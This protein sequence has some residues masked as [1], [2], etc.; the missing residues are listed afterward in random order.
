MTAKA[1]RWL[2]AA[3]VLVGA[4]HLAKADG[5]I[6][7]VDPELRVRGSWAVKY[8]RVDIAVRD[9]IAQVTVDQAFVNT[10]RGEIEVEYLF[11]I[12]PGAAI[13]AMT[14]MADGQELPGRLMGA[15]EARRIYEEIVRRKKD[16]ALLEY[17]GYGLYRTSVFPLPPGQ[18]RR[19]IVNYTVPCTKDGDLVRIHYPLNT[20]KFSAR[21]IEDVRVTVD[22]HNGQP[23]G[24]VYSPTHDLA[25]ERHSPTHVTATYQ[26]ANAIPATDFEVVYQ[27]GSG[28]IGATVV[29]YRPDAGEDGYVM[30]LVS[31]AARQAAAIE[32]K[33]IV[34]VIDQSGSMGGQK[35]AQVREALVWVLQNLNSEDR[36]NVVPFSSSVHA[37]FTDPLVAADAEHTAR[38]AELV[39]QLQ[40]G[41]G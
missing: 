10:G 36:F 38:A 40:A 1:L 39:R 19:V 7:P 27:D 28:D 37:M 22:I 15:D 12:P 5:M 2:A 33:D 25:T 13:T 31:P 20:E 8:H 14:L 29:S 3:G 35:I 21:A 6:V 26:V 23:I 24:P 30:A 17:V 32:P 18:E 41:G 16:P 34:F 11:P 4:A 9:Q